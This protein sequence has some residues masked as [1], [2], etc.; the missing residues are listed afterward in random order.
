M[1]RRRYKDEEYDDDRPVQTG[2]HILYDR[3]KTDKNFITVLISIFGHVA[4]SIWWASG[5]NQKVTYMAQSNVELRS[6]IKELKSQLVTNM[7]DRYRGTDAKRD[8]FI[9]DQIIDEMEKRIDHLEIR[10]PKEVPPKWFYNEFNREVE[11]RK[12]LENR[13]DELEK[14]II[15]GK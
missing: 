7:D 6:E 10:T 13:I 1:A 11:S 3:R 9:R 8:F 12:D 5:I 2:G 14:K 4:L 15:R